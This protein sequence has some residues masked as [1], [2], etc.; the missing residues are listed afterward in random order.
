MINVS[1]YYKMVLND[2]KEYIHGKGK[3]L[4]IP[5]LLEENLKKIYELN[6]EINKKQFYCFKDKNIDIDFIW[7]CSEDMIKISK[8]GKYGCMDKEE[9]IIVPPI[10]DEIQGFENGLAIVILNDKYGV[11]NKKGEIIIPIIYRK[12]HKWGDDAFSI[13]TDSF[14]KKYFNVKGEEILGL[15]KYS[16]RFSVNDGIIEVCFKNKH[17]YVDTS[18]GKE[19]IPCIYDAGERYSDGIIAVKKGKKWGGIDKNNQ[20]IIPFI[21]DDSFKFQDGLAIVSLNDKC[22]VINKK[23]VIDK[24]NNIVIPFNYIYISRLN[25][26][27]FVGHKGNSS[28]NISV[29]L[30][31]KTGKKVNIRSNYYIFIG[32]YY[33]GLAVCKNFAGKFGYI[34]T[35]GKE[36]I[37]CSYKR[38]SEFCNGVASVEKKGKYG[39]VTKDGSFINCGAKYPMYF[40]TNYCDCYKNGKCGIIDKNGQEIIPFVFNGIRRITDNLFK[41]V[42]DFEDDSKYY[43]VD[44]N[45]K[46]ELLKFYDELKKIVKIENIIKFTNN[47]D[48]YAYDIDTDKVI[49]VNYWDKETV[50]END[51]GEKINLNGIETTNLRHILR[52]GNKR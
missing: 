24:N 35:T 23:G 21:Y 47:K 11:I 20:L 28:N 52:K 40:D 37:P 17:G 32:D 18:N 14:E 5:E 2:N 29:D 30:F 43:F 4:L 39:L 48:Y 6:G 22:R 1:E 33:E 16:K 41:F 46:K 27:M 25:N 44:L 36:V 8:N 34:D 12:I 45:T 13:E 42:Y 7:S 31:D 51:R 19:I 3:L 15:N 9:N 50:I 26:G 49:E 38:V 10:Y